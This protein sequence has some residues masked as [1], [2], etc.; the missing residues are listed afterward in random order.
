MDDDVA[1]PTHDPK[2]E[3]EQAAKLGYPQLQKDTSP[4]ALLGPSIKCLEKI[5]KKLQQPLDALKPAE[6]DG[7]PQPPPAKK[8][9][10]T[11]LKFPPELVRGEGLHKGISEIV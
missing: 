6:P 9:K 11:D 5:K 4:S 1:A 2:T 10:P 8:L 3:A 7:Q